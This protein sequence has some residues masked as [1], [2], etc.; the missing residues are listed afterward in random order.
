MACF[1]VQK[2]IPSFP[3]HKIVSLNLWSTIS[4]SSNIVKNRCYCFWK[5]GICKSLVQNCMKDKNLVPILSRNSF[6][7]R[8]SMIRATNTCRIMLYGFRTFSLIHL[9]HII[10]LIHIINQTIL[11]LLWATGRLKAEAG[12]KGNTSFLWNPDFFF[13]Q[14]YGPLCFGLILLCECVRFFLFISVS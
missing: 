11:L 2:Y 1:I 8:S 3:S 13:S 12:P 5:W 4:L 10:S 14:D 9:I 7:M 6:K